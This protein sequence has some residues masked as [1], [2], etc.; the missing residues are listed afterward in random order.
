M[1]YEE[2]TSPRYID[3]YKFTGAIHVHHEDEGEE[4]N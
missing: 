3:G 1:D 2:F 4:N